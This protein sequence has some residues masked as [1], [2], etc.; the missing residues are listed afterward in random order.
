MQKAAP[1]TKVA[2]RS[3]KASG[4]YRN[5]RAKRR[6]QGPQERS[7]V[8]DVIAQF[9]DQL[10][11][12]R[13]LV[14]NAI[15][16]GSDEIGV[17]LAYDD[18]DGEMRVSVIDHGS[19]MDRD[20]LE[21]GLVV[22]FRSTKEDRDDA[23]GKFGIGFVSVLAVEPR[24]VVVRSRRD[25]VMWTLRLA[26]DF[27]YTIDREDT[28]QPVGTTVNLFIPMTPEEAEAFVTESHE[29][30]VRWCQHAAVPIRMRARLAHKPDFMLDEDI[31]RE[32]G[33]DDA[34]VQVSVS[35][36]HDGGLPTRAV[37]AI[38]EDG[39]TEAAY[40][41]RG[42]TLYVGRQGSFRGV[43]F[44]VQGPKLGHTLSR[45]NV[46]HDQ[47]YLEARTLVQ[48]ALQRELRDALIA[49]ISEAANKGREEHNRVVAAVAEALHSVSLKRA[50]WSFPLVQPIGEVRSVALSEWGL[51]AVNT[52]PR[53]S[54][55]TDELRKRGIA[56]VHV[57][58]TPPERTRLKDLL[59]ALRVTTSDV[60]SRYEFLR[61]E[62]LTEADAAWLALSSELLDRI[63]K[64][65]SLL[66]VSRW[67]TGGPFT[68]SGPSGEDASGLVER[69]DLYKTPFGAFRSRPV[70]LFADH[71]LIEALRDRARTDPALAAYLLVRA[72]FVQY[73]GDGDRRSEALLDAAMRLKR[74]ILG[75]KEA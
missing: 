42:L 30:L 44:K 35:Q 15:D 20:I 73:G 32:L 25:G 57:G 3:A 7:L 75:S 39:T 47:A 58:G 14:Q 59:R 72:L 1:P 38:L 60:E 6:D 65:R 29:A 68:G 49:R 24:E 52:A 46:R 56:V 33:F 62:P 21:N 9:A 36:A 4:P 13:E 55:I 27:S 70:L 40:Y 43:A 37:V 12:Y 48:R 31:Q 74:P 50:D 41:N 5:S 64:E 66:L 17:E 26:L 45:D 53:R 69:E 67:R 19:G 22:L 23:I 51:K 61:D 34:I 18:E 63:W 54:P 16:A 71:P 8:D 28:E 11:F 10:A 2:A